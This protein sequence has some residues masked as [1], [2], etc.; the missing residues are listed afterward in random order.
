MLI[1]LDCFVVNSDKYA[2]LTLCNCG[3]SSARKESSL[4][5]D[6]PVDVSTTMTLTQLTLI[7]ILLGCLV[8]W[9][10][11]FAILALRPDRKKSEAA[12]TV[13]APHTSYKKTLV[14]EMLGVLTKTPVSARRVR[15]GQLQH[16]VKETRSVPVH[17]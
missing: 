12:Q 15:T 9:T 17:F 6:V 3:L 1:S 13:A 8:A 4:K 11:F 16:E 14:P 5:E 7:W 2:D 10:L